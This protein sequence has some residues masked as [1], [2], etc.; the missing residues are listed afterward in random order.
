MLAIEMASVRVHSQMRKVPFIII[1]NHVQD[2]HDLQLGL[3]DPRSD[4]D[5]GGR[6]G[7]KTY[8]DDGH[9]DRVGKGESCDVG[10]KCLDEAGRLAKGAYQRDI[11]SI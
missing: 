10:D 8:D 2:E 3:D 6:D 4:F 7:K 5:V 1:N 9:H 11:E